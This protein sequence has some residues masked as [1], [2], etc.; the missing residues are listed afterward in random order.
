MNLHKGQAPRIESDGPAY[1]IVL[2][3]NSPLSGASI[4]ITSSVPIPKF[5]YPCGNL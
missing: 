2:R 3:R 4:E 1:P 5:A